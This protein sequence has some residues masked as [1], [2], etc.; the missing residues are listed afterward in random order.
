MAFLSTQGCRKI[1]WK[2]VK[3][4]FSF[5]FLE[6]IYQH[7]VHEIISQARKNDVS[8][9]RASPHCGGGQRNPARGPYK[10]GIRSS[11]GPGKM[12]MTI[13]IFCLEYQFVSRLLLY[14]VFHVFIC[15]NGGVDKRSES[16]WS[17]VPN[18][19]IGTWFRYKALKP[20]KSPCECEPLR[21]ISLSGPDV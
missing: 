11:A 5:S 17:A 2:N 14:Q 15:Y 12:N 18:L 3:V 8:P 19:H 9:P 7:T 10:S 6:I 13:N 16:Y 21:A 1:F 4:S 20:S